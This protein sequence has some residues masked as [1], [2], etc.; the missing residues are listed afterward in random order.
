LVLSADGK[1]RHGIRNTQE[2][3]IVNS[4]SRRRFDK[5]LEEV[6]ADM[7]PLVHQLLEKIALAVEDYP[8]RQVMEEMDIEYRDELCGLYSG[9]PLGEKHLE[10]PPHLSDAV[11]IYR[12]GIVAETAEQYGRITNEGLRKQI[13]ITI[14]HELAHH[15]GM[16]EEALEQLGYG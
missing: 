16:T 10:S 7:P 11:L 9:I 6:L 3:I 13:R 2:E 12:E 5:I 1:R 8:S 15:F 4:S 14:L